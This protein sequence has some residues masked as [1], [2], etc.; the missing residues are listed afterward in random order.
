MRDLLAEQASLHMR[1]HSFGTREK[2]AVLLPTAYHEEMDSISATG[3][4][5]IF[6]F[7]DRPGSTRVTLRESA[8]EI[9]EIVRRV[10][11]IVH[12]VTG[13]PAFRVRLFGSW[14]S[15]NP[16]PHSD[17]DIAIDGPNPVDPAHMA[18]IRD[19]V[20]RLPTLFT[21]DLVDLATVSDA[22]RRSVQKQFDKAGG[23]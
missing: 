12:R 14:A 11:A 2:E 1:M 10:E 3:E 21:I 18:D 15:G 4:V 6:G 7:D 9:R 13:D 17:I 23:R 8:V 22:F 16:R 19:A 5:E 20:E